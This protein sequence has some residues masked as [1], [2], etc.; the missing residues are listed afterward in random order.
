MY[1]NSRLVKC[2]VFQKAIDMVYRNL[3]GN[4]RYPFIVL[5]LEIPPADVDVNVHPAKRE[6]RYKNPNQILILYHLP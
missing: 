5:N 3:T 2:P 4:S 6:V 1:V